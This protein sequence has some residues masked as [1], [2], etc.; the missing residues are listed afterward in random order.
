[1]VDGRRNLTEQSIGQ[2]G[3]GLGLSA[4]EQ[5]FFAA[6]VHYN[7]AQDAATKQQWLDVLRGHQRKVQAVQVSLD[8]HQYYA[9]WYYPVLRELAATRA[10]NGDYARLARAVRPAIT[11]TQAKDGIELLLRL[12]FL[13][14]EKGRWVQTD[15]A[16]TTGAEVDSLLVR[17]C[18]KQFAELAVDSIDALPPTR[19]DVSSMVLGVSQRSWGLIKEEIQHFKARVARIV[20][21]DATSDQVCVLNVQLVP[22]SQEAE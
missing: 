4:T 22:H 9:H 12:G 15:P 17:G 6:L 3:L 18:N 7:Q 10:W 8:A 13:R 14:E 19:R 21:D 1:V 5:K 2:F 11:K 16:L 20:E